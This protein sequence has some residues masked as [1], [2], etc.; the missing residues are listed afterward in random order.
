[1]LKLEDCMLKSNKEDYYIKKANMPIEMTG[2]TCNT[3]KDL[4]LICF[5]YNGGTSCIK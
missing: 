2:H 3:F 1:M 5:G 4:V